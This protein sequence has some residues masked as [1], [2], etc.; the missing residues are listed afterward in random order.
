[1]FSGRML[2]NNQP[3][4]HS[5]V[6]DYWIES[7]GYQKNLVAEV[8]S[9]FLGAIL[10]ALSS[11][12]Y[13]P[14][15]FTPVPITLQTFSVLTLSTLMGSRRAPMSVLLYLAL[16]ALG[17][18]VLAE[19]RSGIE[20]MVGATG[21]YLIGFVLAS[22]FV[23]LLIEKGWDRSLVKGLFTFGVGQLLIFVPGLLWLGMFVGYESVFEK[24]FFPFIPGGIVKTLLGVTTSVLVWKW[25]DKISEKKNG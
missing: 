18:P 17:F 19:G 1:M 23:G 4:T 25:M 24:G 20:V 6:M 10:I 16:S 8:A 14:L 11:Q 9:L 12:I 3:A 2:L 21:G 7:K 15:S 22:Y 13:I 5:S